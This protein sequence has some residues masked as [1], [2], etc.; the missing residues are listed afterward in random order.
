[1]IIRFAYLPPLGNATPTAATPLFI[2]NMPWL[3][4]LNASECPVKNAP[5]I[6]VAARIDIYFC[7]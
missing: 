4:V 6:G 5:A 2:P 1:M 7:K 3:I